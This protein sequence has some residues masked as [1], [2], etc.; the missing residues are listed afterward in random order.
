MFLLTSISRLRNSNPPNGTG[1]PIP[2]AR[3]PI[4]QLTKDVRA[5][6]VLFRREQSVL[7]LIK[8]DLMESVL[9][10]VYFPGPS[11]SH[12][13]R[14]DWL[15]D[16]CHFLKDNLSGFDPDVQQLLT[17]H[18]PFLR[19]AFSPRI[20]A[21]WTIPQQVLALCSNRDYH[22]T[23]AS[24]ALVMRTTRSSGD[25]PPDAPLSKVKQCD[26]DFGSGKLEA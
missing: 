20:V 15:L 23:E 16:L 1:L 11:T 5:L 21:V 13:M 22:H 4:D 7:P 19:Q 8:K 9:L 14:A 12:R 26:I 10:S 24:V 6:N 2:D 25:A 18:L 17:D 3:R